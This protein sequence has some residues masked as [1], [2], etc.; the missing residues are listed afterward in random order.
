MR[1]PPLIHS[2]AVLLDTPRLNRRS[3]R[4]RTV[5]RSLQTD[6]GASLAFAMAPGP[7]EHSP[8]VELPPASNPSIV[9]AGSCN[10]HSC[11]RDTGAASKPPRFSAYF[12][13]TVYEVFDTALAR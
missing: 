2:G 12:A 8:V 13:A 7:C 10:A 11:E 5:P 6:F 4:N 1:R 3:Q 9:W